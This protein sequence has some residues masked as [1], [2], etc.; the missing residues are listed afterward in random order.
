M[1][2]FLHWHVLKGHVRTKETLRTNFILVFIA[3]GKLTLASS[4]SMTRTSVE[5]TTT[6]Y[7]NRFIA[8]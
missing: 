1:F 5:P 6:S 4:P 7:L 3:K 8:S 2:I